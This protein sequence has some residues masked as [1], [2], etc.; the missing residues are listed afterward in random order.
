MEPI[1]KEK[2][3]DEEVDKQTDQYLLKLR[4]HYHIRQSDLDNYL[5]ANFEPFILK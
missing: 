3:M 5:P 2:L 1:L 4:Q